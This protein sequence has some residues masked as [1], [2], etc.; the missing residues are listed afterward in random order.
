MGVKTNITFRLLAFERS[1]RC[2]TV[3]FVTQKY[4]FSM[5][6]CYTVIVMVT[7]AMCKQCPEKKHNNNTTK[8]VQK[9]QAYAENAF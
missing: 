6:A 8:I 3:L 7:R 1:T 9:P 5:L 4:C 2:H